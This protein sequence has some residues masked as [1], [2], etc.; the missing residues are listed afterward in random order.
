MAMD[1]QTA[2]RWLCLLPVGSLVAVE[3][4]VAGFDGWGAW[5]TAPMLLLPALVSVPIV[6]WGLVRIATRRRAR[7]S[8][9]AT[10][11]WTIVAALPILWLAVRRLVV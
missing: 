5:A 9:V 8:Y 11:G 1:D 4:Y 6:I 10:L 7:V 2:L 3:V